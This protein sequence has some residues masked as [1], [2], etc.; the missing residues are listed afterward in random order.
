MLE[1]DNK[2]IIKRQIEM[3]NNV[4]ITNIII[5]RGFEAEKI[6]YDDVK[7]YDNKNY[8]ETNMLYSLF[9]AENELNEEVI[10]SYS[11]IVFEMNL[12]E[13]LIKYEGNVVVPVDINWKE[14]WEE[15]YGRIDKDTESL[16]LNNGK[17]TSL[18]VEDVEPEEMEARYIGLVKLSKKGC[19]YFKEIWHKDKNEYWNKPW[20]N[21]NKNLKNAYLTDML[22]AVVDK[23]YDVEAMKY[24]RGWYEF[25]TNKDYEKYKNLI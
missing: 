7:Y 16:H 9:C 6:D 21:S 15:R 23:G 3:F 20:K 25:D 1:V 12:L 19:Q 14:Y 11:D 4:G 13:K 18:G 24:K 22:Q 5:I 17:I 2:T 10:V 8:D